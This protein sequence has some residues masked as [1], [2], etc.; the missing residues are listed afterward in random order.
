MVRSRVAVAFCTV[1]L[2]STAVAQEEGTVPGAIPDPST[3]QGS[4][5]MQR[6]SDAQDQQFRQ[7]Q[8]QQSEQQQQAYGQQQ[9]Y[10]SSGSSQGYAAAAP[11]GTRSQGAGARAAM[12]SNPLAAAFQRGDYATVLK[13]LRPK[14]LAG[15]PSAQ[16]NLGY[17]YEKGF[18]VPR[19]PATAA[20]WYQKSANQGY[21]AGQLALGR[22]YFEGDGLKRDLVEAYKW[23]Y[24]AGR[25]TSRAFQYL[26]VIGNMLTYDQMSEA[27]RRGQ[28][29][30][31]T[32]RR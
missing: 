26:N 19:N 24:L 17:M 4:M 8:Q 9:S 18:G 5:E 15:N 25:G 13:I 14:A 12:P 21:P 7:Q 22:L 3:Y 29:W 32:V 28:L 11:R 1:L 10:G 23:M 31:P 20:S 6:Q 30:T 2:S 16:H 27:M